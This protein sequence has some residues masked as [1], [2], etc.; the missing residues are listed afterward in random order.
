MRCLML[1]RHAK[2]APLDGT[3]RDH[4]RALQARG[5]KDAQKMGAYMARH[6]LV[7]DQVIVSTAKRARETWALAAPAFSTPPPVVYDD[8]LYEAEP[9][10]IFEVIREAVETT[11]ALLLVGHNPGLHKL[12]TLLIAAGNVDARERLHEEFPTAGL[13]TID[14]AFDDWKKLHLQAGRLDRFVSPRSLTIA[15]D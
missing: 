12:A 1:L 13:V 10:A 3:G 15:T 7:P 8:R 2:S 4:D 14:F 11:H 5:R 9:D 6:A